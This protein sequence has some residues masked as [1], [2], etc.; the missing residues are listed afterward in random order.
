MPSGG[1]H[2]DWSVDIADERGGPLDVDREDLLELLGNLLD[3]ACKWARGQVRC[4]LTLAGEC[5][6]VRVE[7]DGPGAPA[8]QAAGGG[9]ADSITGRGVRLDE[10]VGGH[11]LGLAIVS[12]IVAAHRGRLRFYAAP[13]L[14]G[15]GV[16][17]IIPLGAGPL[18]AHADE[19]PG[20]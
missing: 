17:V 4:R 18:A 8:A 12:E 5:L 9:G 16:E 20:Q 19:G 15:F 14:G 3:N 6:E 2:I 13:Q 7:D 1:L 10:A 11:G